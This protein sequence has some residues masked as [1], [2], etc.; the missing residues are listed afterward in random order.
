MK[1]A[2]IFQFRVLPGQETSYAD[3]LR[4]VVAP[5]DEAAHRDGIFENLVT[6]V[7]EAADAGWNHGRIFIFRDAA[8]REV[9]AAGIAGHAAAFDGN[10]DATARRKAF[11]EQLRTLIAVCDFQIV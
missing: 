3:Y 4:D 7:P 10:A 8:Q 9:F 1:C 6:I 11:A 5:I 2:R